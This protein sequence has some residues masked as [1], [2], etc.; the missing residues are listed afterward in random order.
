[1][2]KL[3]MFLILAVAMSAANG[4][5]KAKQ[6]KDGNYVA[7]D[8][9]T[10]GELIAAGKT[11]TDGKGQTFPLYKTKTGKFFYLKTSKK[12]GKQYRSYITIEN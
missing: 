11:F 3:L 1:M 5:T 4:Q 9:S 8:T 2:K 6:T 12:T 10:G 7:I